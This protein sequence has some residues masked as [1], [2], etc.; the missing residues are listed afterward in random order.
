MSLI[1]SIW[2]WGLLALIIPVIIHFWNRQKTAI[3]PFG[4]IKFLTESASTKSKSIQFN[5]FWLFLV[6]L[7]LLGCLVLFL[8]G[9]FTRQEASK[10]N[11]LIKGDNITVPSNLELNYNKVILSSSLVNKQKSLD[12]WSV[13]IQL[14][15][16]H[17]EIDSVL[18]V[19][20]FDQFKFIGAVPELPFVLKLL[21]KGSENTQDQIID[22]IDTLTYSISGL[23]K[24]DSLV[25]ERVLKT[26]TSYVNSSLVLQHAVKGGLIN[27]YM[28]DKEE[29]KG[30]LNF[31]FTAEIENFYDFDY[32]ADRKI[33]YCTNDLLTDIR[34]H[35]ELLLLIADQIAQFEASQ[36]ELQVEHLT[37]EFPITARSSDKVFTKWPLSD[38]I[39]MAIILMLLILERYMVFRK[40]TYGG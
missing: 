35:Q 21:H 40:S 22:Q 24:H 11:W 16:A 17:P 26:I 3:I 36:F 31:I 10:E 30:N 4:S 5:D 9:L 19:D 2:L 7:L 25:I 27:F 20:E 38:E 13:L 29:I 34:K 8:A 33:V 37:R 39:F 18:W 1:N 23:E 6:R 15:L 28:V 12:A 14:A 32:E